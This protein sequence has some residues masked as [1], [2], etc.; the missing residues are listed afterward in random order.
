MIGE[1]RRPGLYCRAILY[2]LRYNVRKGPF[3]RLATGRTDF[4]LGAMRRHFDS[5]R[6]KIEHLALFISHHLDILQGRVTMRTDGDLMRHGPL[7]MLHSHK[8]LAL[9]AR[10]ATMR[11]VTGF[12]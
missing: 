7:R 10:L 8:R 9:M 5:D 12:P 1:V 4:N 2:R 6:R 3:A 11:L